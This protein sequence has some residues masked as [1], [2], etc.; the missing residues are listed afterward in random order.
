MMFFCT[1]DTANFV[2]QQ[3][4]IFK[5][6]T[7]GMLQSLSS[8]KKTGDNPKN[9]TKNL[10]NVSLEFIKKNYIINLLPSYRS[11][12][13]HNNGSETFV[14]KCSFASVFQYIPAELHQKCLELLY[15]I[16][17]NLNDKVELLYKRGVNGKFK[18]LLFQSG[19]HKIYNSVIGDGDKFFFGS[20]LENLDNYIILKMSKILLQLNELSISSRYGRR[21]SPIKPGKISFH[22]GIDLTP[23]LRGNTNVHIIAIAPGIVKKTEFRHDYGNYVVI[24][25][26]NGVISLYGHMSK[27]FVKPGDKIAFGDSLGLMGKTGYATGIHVHLEFRLLKDGKARRLNPENHLIEKIKNN[28]KKENTENLLYKIYINKLLND[29]LSEISQ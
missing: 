29:M 22:S 15:L 18:L 19:H 9:R 12:R 11:S 27:L 13:K 10:L 8:M 21:K 14:I 16:D 4:Q 25:H 23:K 24:D 17:A 26:G 7:E 1:V 2:E 3:L 20:N 5:E 6:P 28:N